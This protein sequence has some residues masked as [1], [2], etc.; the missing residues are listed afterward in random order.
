MPRTVGEV[1]A[2]VKVRMGP[3]D[4]LRALAVALSAARTGLGIV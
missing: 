2:D 1:M 4:D 3:Q